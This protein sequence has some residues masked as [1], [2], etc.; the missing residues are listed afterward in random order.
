MVVEPKTFSVKLVRLG[1]PPYLEVG[2]YKYTAEALP[3][4]GDMI[5]LT[6]ILNPWGPRPHEIRA[7]VTRV[8][9]IAAMPI[10]ATEVE[11]D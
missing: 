4:E 8:D 7:R 5:T 6:S 2:A 10:S 11:R 3:A 9:P 1:L